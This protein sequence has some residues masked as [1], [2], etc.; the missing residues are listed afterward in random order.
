M[1]IEESAL[2]NRLGNFLSAFVDRNDLG[3]IAWADG[4]IRLMPGLVRIP[5]VS[6]VSWKQLPKKFYPTEPIPDRAPYL[7]VEVLSKS[8]TKDEMDIKLRD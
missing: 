6:F 7:A 2:G 4:T 5:D 1:G 3:F 8:N